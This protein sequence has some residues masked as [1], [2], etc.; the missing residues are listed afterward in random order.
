MVVEPV[1]EDSPY[2]T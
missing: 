1:K 2:Q